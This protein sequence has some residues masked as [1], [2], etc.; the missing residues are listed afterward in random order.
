MAKDEDYRLTVDDVRRFEARHGT[1]P[2]G[3]MVLLRTGWDAR[4][5]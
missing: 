5:R 4:W 2:A 3:A 1:I